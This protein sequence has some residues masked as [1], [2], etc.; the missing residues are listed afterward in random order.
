MYTIKEITTK[1]DKNEDFEIF[2]ILNSW[3]GELEYRIKIWHGLPL[4]I[5]LQ[6]LGLAEHRRN[7]LEA[8]PAWSVDAIRY[9]SWDDEESED[10]ADYF[11]I[12]QTGGQ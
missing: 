12:Q 8:V 11:E 4:A 1:Q 9:I 7:P 3:D 6:S 2:E 10:M 5:A